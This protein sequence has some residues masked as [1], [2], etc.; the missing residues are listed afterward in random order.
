V[1][2]DPDALEFF[3]NEMARLHITCDLAESGEVAI[4]MIARNSLYDMYF[5]D[6]KMPGMDG[7]QT[8]QKIK[9]M[10]AGK[11]S[12]VALISGADWNQI[13]Q[14]AQKA[15]IDR[16]LQ[17]PLF[18]SEIVDCLNTYFG[19]VPEKPD[20]PAAAFDDFSRY[21]AL[22][23]EDVE[24]NREIVLALLE[25][26]GISVDCAE[27]G[28]AAVEMVQS[29]SEPYDLVLMDV[30]MPEMDG[31]EATRKIREHEATMEKP[32]HVPIIAMTANVFRE[33]IEKCL[34]AGMDNHV[35]KPLDFGDVLEKLKI[36]LR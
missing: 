30:Q 5:I 22:L 26:T 35:G 10:G 21:R 34:Q 29:A 9:E 36:Y 6:W 8:A 24:I 7:I 1:D 28:I 31:Y 12:V 11:S 19:T 27:N 16:F 14:D 32:P 2:D 15:K 25:P 20:S 33:D 18:R 17:K 4:A 3:Q 23:A 13:E